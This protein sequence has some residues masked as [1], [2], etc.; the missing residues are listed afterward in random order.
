MQGGIQ[1]AARSL[2]GRPEESGCVA[3]MHAEALT[4]GRFSYVVNPVNSPGP[5]ISGPWNP[6]TE[7]KIQM[8]LLGPVW[9]AGIFSYFCI[10]P[11]K[12]N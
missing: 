10:F 3:C 7:I 4:F 5:E 6:G 2:S 11:V 9:N 8:L 1:P 12:L